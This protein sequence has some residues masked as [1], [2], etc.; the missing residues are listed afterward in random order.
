MSLWSR[1]R[2][3]SRAV[4]RSRVRWSMRWRRRTKGLHSA[5]PAARSAFHTDRRGGQQPDR[6]GQPHLGGHQVPEELADG[7]AGAGRAE[8]EVE[9]DVLPEV[10]GHEDVPA[11]GLLGAGHGQHDADAGEAG[12][13][14][15]PPVPAALEQDHRLPE[16]P[17]DDGQ[18]GE[19]DQQQHDQQ[20]AVGGRLAGGAGDRLAGGG[21]PAARV[22]QDRWGGSRGT[23]GAQVGGPRHVG[24]RVDLDGMAGPD[25]RSWPVR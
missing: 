21:L 25:A 1:G 6:D 9:G 16:Q 17:G 3:T 4:L 10:L 23:S 15:A 18:R 22:A 7:D 19:P 2:A 13:G 20:Q 14:E 8:A 5:P 24:Q 11:Q 12:E